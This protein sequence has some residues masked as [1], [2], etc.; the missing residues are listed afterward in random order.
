MASAPSSG[1]G[2]HQ[3]QLYNITDATVTIVGSV[4]H[5]TNGSL[6]QTWSH[7]TGRFTTAAQKV[8][9]IRHWINLGVA[10]G[11]GNPSSSSTDVEVYTDV[12]I[13]KLV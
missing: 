10:D 11:L 3:A 1:A 13:W 9:S 7:I 2:S 6:T 5:C 8:F 4:E 12:M